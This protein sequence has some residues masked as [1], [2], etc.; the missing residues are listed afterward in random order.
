MKD[1]LSTT[2]WTLS[3]MS[4]LWSPSCAEEV[5]QIF[6]PLQKLQGPF[7]VHSVIMIKKYFP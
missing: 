7:H 3:R 4:S 1:L 6:L 5:N 2:A